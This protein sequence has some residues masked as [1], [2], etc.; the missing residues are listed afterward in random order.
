MLLPL[1]KL[2]G[3]PNERLFVLPD[4]LLAEAL[5]RQ[6][7]APPLLFHGSQPAGSGASV[8]RLRDTIRDA[9]FAKRISNFRVVCANRL[10]GIRLQLSEEAA[11]KISILW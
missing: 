5:L 9:L 3:Q 1:V 8:F 10:I 4:W 7:E 2:L 11:K 6:H